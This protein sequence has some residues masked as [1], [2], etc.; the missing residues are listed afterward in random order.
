MIHRSS[1]SPRIA[2]FTPTGS[3]LLLRRHARSEK[4][5]AILIPQIAAR[6][7][8]AKF[9]VVKAGP[10]AQHV[11]AGDVVLAPCQLQFGRIELDD[12]K[13]E[14]ATEDLMAAVIPQ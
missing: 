13:L 12:E 2:N 6:T 5:G 11:R 8:M 4:V 10:K 3:K 1:L 9:D 14:I 7:E